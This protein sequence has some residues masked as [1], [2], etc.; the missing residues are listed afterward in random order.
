MAEFRL[1]LL[2]EHARERSESAARELQR[3]RHQ[4]T[5]AEE[6]IKQLQQ[7]L[8]DYHDR[9]NDTSATGMTVGDMRDFQRFI[10]KLELAIR[11][12]SEEVVRCRERWEAG[13]RD[14][15]ERER[16]VKAYDAL[17]QRHEREE[18]HKENKRDQRLQDEF[19]Q[20][21]RLRRAKE[22]TKDDSTE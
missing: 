18:M 16:E 17:R 6:K 20:N 13:Q 14:W 21:Q 15:A 10:A 22:D 8:S 9:L 12:Q 5:L 2:L 11:S 4:W 7:Y 1:Q 19:S 3:L